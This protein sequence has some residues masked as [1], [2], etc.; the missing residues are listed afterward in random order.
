MKEIKLNIR[1][2]NAGKYTALVDDEDFE[3]VNQFNWTV[4]IGVKTSYA[5]RVDGKTKIYM[6]RF[7]MNTSVDVECDHISGVGL[8]NQKYNLRNCTHRQNMIN[9]N[10]PNR[11]CSSIY[12]GV[13]FN[14]KKNIYQAYIRAEDRHIYLGCSQIEREMAIAYD[15]AAIFYHGKFANTN[16]SAHGI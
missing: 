13:Y 8:N 7:I 3:R 10:K 11:N 5:I 12:K 15:T 4:D 6:H 16:F 2:K 1:G 14:K 9:K